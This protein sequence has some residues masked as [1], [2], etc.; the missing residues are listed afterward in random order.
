MRTLTWLSSVAFTLAAGCTDSGAS[1]SR[2]PQEPSGEGGGAGS[3][4]GESVTS[5]DSTS[6]TTSGGQGGDGGQGGAPAQPLGPGQHSLYLTAADGT[7]IAVTAWL[8]D[9]VET[10]QVATVVRFTR[11]WRATDYVDE[12][13]AEIDV[14]EQLRRAYLEQGFAYVAVD[15]RGTGASFGANEG[16]WSSRE[17]ADA[18]V[19]LDWLAN[20][21]WSAGR[22]FTIGTSYDGNAAVLAAA[23]EHP[24]LA[25][26]VARFYD[27]DPFGGLAF[28]G[29]LYTSGFVDAWSDYTSAL[30]RH[31]L[32][33]VAAFLG[34]TCEAYQDEVRGPLAVIPEDLAVVAAARGGNLD[35]AAAMT[36]VFHRDDPLGTGESL[37]AVAPY[38][39]H[40]AIS[41][42]GVPMLVTASW[43]DSGTAAGALDGFA[44][45]SNPQTVIIGAF[46]HGGMGDNDPLDAPLP[47]ADPAIE[48]QYIEAIT[49]MMRTA[50]GAPPTERVIRYVTLGERTWRTTTTWPPASTVTWSMPF[51]SE[52]T[53]RAPDDGAGPPGTEQ[54]GVDLEAT[55]G[56]KNR[57]LTPLDNSASDYGDRAAQDDALLTYTAPALEGDVRVTGT[58]VVRLRLAVDQP[59]AAVIV[60]LEDVDPDG[61]SRYVTEGNL[62]LAHRAGGPSGPGNER[63][64]G[65]SYR[66]EHASP[67]TPGE[68]T[69]VVIPLQPTSALFRAGH[70][71]RVAIA[72]ADA[73]TFR[74]VTPEGTH[75]TVHHG[76]GG[77]V[78]ELPVDEAE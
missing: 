64:T 29:G 76:T 22:A 8:P 51:G 78:L 67:M 11:Y 42:S 36:N 60:Y 77:S 20:E 52:G 69:E 66:A 46:T 38:R 53:L 15:A 58:P 41:R 49:F 3:T 2:A 21:P 34:T 14:Y 44:T 33:G 32:C 12:D 40:E 57:W 7:R 43:L 65:R 54:H 17:Q 72:G 26:V 6:G 30:D 47:T 31:D 39:H 23:L 28:P 74:G 63:V 24:V 70:R 62:R 5:G 35:L 75:F 56:P 71:V 13:A 10:E 9:A 19:V 27:Y 68:A 25:G 61:V 48:S 45:F 37:D 73:G 50:A 55:S 1:S 4:S 18:R 59:D 16:P